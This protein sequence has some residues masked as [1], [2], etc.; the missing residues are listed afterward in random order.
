MVKKIFSVI[1]VFGVLFFLLGLNHLQA[2]PQDQKTPIK[3]GMITNLSGPYA[4]VGK[5]ALTIGID[6]VNKGGGIL[7]RSL[8][9]VV[10]DSR[11]QMPTAVAAY[12]KLVI[13]E[14]V[15]LVVVN[16]AIPA[17]SRD[18]SY[19]FPIAG[20]HQDLG[21][22]ERSVRANGNPHSLPILST[23]H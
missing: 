2:A 12:K 16:E 18:G 13:T 8:K 4:E 15:K 7:G 23:A 21:K 20:L 1:A 14:G 22:D 17:Y 6:E 10:E 19:Q 11:G 9:M 5:K 3:I